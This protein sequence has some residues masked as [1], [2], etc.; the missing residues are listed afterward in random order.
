[1]DGS[2][3]GA[4]LCEVKVPR[5]T[6]RVPPAAQ[7]RLPDD[8][9]NSPSARARA[10]A[11]VGRV[12]SDRYRVE[13][14]VA[15][16]GM[17]AVYRGEHLLMHKQLAIKV[18]HPEIEGFPE[19]VQRFEREAVAGAHINHPNVASASDFGKFDN[20]SYFLVLEYIRGATLSDVMRRG[21][22]PPPRAS[23]IARQ[24]A[25]ALGA[26]HQKG[27]VHRDVKPRNVM[28]VEGE[29]DLVK[30]IDF[31]LARVP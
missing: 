2:E 23:K 12:I 19:L 5:P 15:M 24:L 6:P 13:E 10:A 22:V 29:D 14:L 9:A 18:L 30:L 8:P 26:A 17:G 28:L 1:V 20:D 3:D 31:G 11:M 21:P 25:A 4:R 27:I 7:P 16:G